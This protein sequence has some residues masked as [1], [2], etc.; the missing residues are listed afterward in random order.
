MKKERRS[1][2]LVTRSS[3]APFEEYEEL[4]RKLWDTRF[5]TNMGPYHEE[6]KKSLAGMFGRDTELFVNGHMALEMLLQALDLKGEVITTPFTFVST[7]HAIVR[8]GLTPVMCDVKEEDGTM[9]PE[10]IEALI[11]EK[12]CAILP[13]HVYGHVCDDEAIEAIAKKHGIPVIYDAAHAF[14][15]TVNGTPVAALGDA[16]MLS[17]HATKA[18][19][20]IEGGCVCF[21][22]KKHPGLADRLYKLKNF[23]ITGKESIEYVGGN[24][25]MNEFS[26]AMG[27]VNLRH[28][29]EW[30]AARKEVYDRYAEDLSGVKGV[31]ILRK[32]DDVTYNYAY[33][34]V[35]LDPAYF[36]RDKVYDTM[37]ADGICPRKYFYPLVNDCE[38][39][40]GVLSAAETETPVAYRLSKTV[41]TLPIY[42]DLPLETVDEIC[43][44]FEK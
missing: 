1:P 41:L 29:P 32:P 10:K 6:L 40:R 14:G 13:V 17:F 11:T 20:S 25:K 3:L 23:G 22:E 8:N 43:G 35:V 27:I 18:F 31:R 7:T 5:I 34:P 37:V 16:S 15:E 36:D 19:N 38:C 44:Y 24:A 21:D 4:I 30:A 9:D 28:F 2:I 26:A 12:T 42:P 39:Y 33:M